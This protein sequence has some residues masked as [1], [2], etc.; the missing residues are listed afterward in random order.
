MAEQLELKRQIFAALEVAAPGVPLA[1]NTSSFRVDEVS[2][3]VRARSRVLALHFFNPAPAVRLVEVVGGA[4]SDPSLVARGHVWARG[5]GKVSVGCR[6]EPGFL[7]NRLLIPYLN[8]AIPACAAAAVAP[9]AADACVRDELGHPMGPFEL[10]DLIGLD[11]M[12]S[13]LE[14]MQRGLGSDRYAPAVRLRTLVAQ[15]R[16]GRKTGAGFHDYAV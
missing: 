15:G 4:E 13:A 7:V 6:D 10:M 9:A 12:V 11:V 1:T 5:L 16:L 8:D 3:R 14:T 2:A